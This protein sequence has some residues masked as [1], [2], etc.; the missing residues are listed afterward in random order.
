MLPQAERT[1]WNVEKGWRRGN[2]QVEA[3]A[4]FSA[5]RVFVWLQTEDSEKWILFINIWLTNLRRSD[6]NLNNRHK[7]A[8]NL[9]KRVLRD[10]I[11]TLAH[12]DAQ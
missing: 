6:S 2:L 8:V 5:S 4:R 3:V 7:G 11:K 12:E 9:A 10:T 1:Q